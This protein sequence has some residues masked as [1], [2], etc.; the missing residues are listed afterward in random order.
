MS[1]IREGADLSAYRTE[2]IRPRCREE[3]SRIHEEQVYNTKMGR[4]GYRYVGY[5]FHQTHERMN[6]A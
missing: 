2:R 6:N 4:N 3:L 1:R 5:S